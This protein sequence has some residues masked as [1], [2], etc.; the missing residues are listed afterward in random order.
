MKQVFWS[1]NGLIMDTPIVNNYY[2]KWHFS[3]AHYIAFFFRQVNHSSFKISILT[4]CFQKIEAWLS[5]II[6]TN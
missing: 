4:F 5:S 1:L 2:V 3:N 6:L